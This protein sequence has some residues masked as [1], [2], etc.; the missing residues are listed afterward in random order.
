M[1][2]AQQYQKATRKNHTS[3]Q[4]STDTPSPST[5]TCVL[6]PTVTSVQ[7][8]ID[9]HPRGMVATLILDRD[10]NGD[11]HDHEGHLHNATGV[12]IDI[13]KGVSIHY[14]LIAHRSKLS[15]DQQTTLFVDLNPKYYNS[16]SYFREYKSLR[17]HAQQYQ[18]ATRKNHTSQQTST[19]T[20]SPSTD[21]CVLPPIVTSV[22]NGDLHDHEGHL[23][24][25]TC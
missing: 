25:A 8:S 6:P 14:L 4:T 19:D 7:T 2:H 23:R 3:Q 24:N 13:L 10:A 9:I 16:I 15:P 17:V 20:P 11:L 12:S 22:A 21:S 5:D 1:V 18:K